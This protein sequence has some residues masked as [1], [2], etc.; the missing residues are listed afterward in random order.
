MPIH[1]SSSRPVATASTVRRIPPAN[2]AR[3]YPTG[4]NY[5]LATLT[6]DDNAT[7]FSSAAKLGDDIP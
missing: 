6:D 4:I 1:S 7:N 5:D 2:N 3:L